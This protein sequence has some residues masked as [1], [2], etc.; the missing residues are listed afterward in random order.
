MPRGNTAK[1]N[2]VKKLQEA[3]GNDYVGESDKKYYVWA[4]DGGERVQIALTMT[5]PKSFLEVT[6]PKGEVL[7]PAVQETEFTPEE[8]DRMRSNLRKLGF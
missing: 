4:D 6:P 8:L 2:V 5:C 7:E 1:I 3:F